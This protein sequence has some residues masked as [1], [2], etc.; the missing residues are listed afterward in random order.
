[1]EI[2]TGLELQRIGSSQSSI[3]PVLNTGIHVCSTRNLHIHTGKCTHTSC[4]K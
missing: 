2:S 1:M 4:N 3:I